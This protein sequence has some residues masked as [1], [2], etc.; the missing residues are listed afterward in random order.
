MSGK[1]ATN[2]PQLQ[3]MLEFVHDGDV[4]VSESISRIARRTRDFLNITEILKEKNVTY[5]S[6][7]EAVDVSTPQ[8]IFVTTVL[9]AF[10]ELE[11]P[12]THFCRCR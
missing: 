4:V 11:R 7:K 10:F 5:I 6:K 12:Q 9:A 8:G 3:A 1:D 2:R